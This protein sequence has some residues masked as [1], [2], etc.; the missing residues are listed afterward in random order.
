MAGGRRGGREIAEAQAYLE[1]AGFGR[2]MD[3][4]PG[5]L[6]RSSHGKILTHMPLTP[7]SSYTHVIGALKKAY[8]ISARLEEPDLEFDLEGLT[9]PKWAHHTFRRTA[10]R[11]ARDSMA[12]TGATKGDIDD[13]FG[14][15]Q[16][17]RAKDQQRAYAGIAERSV[18]A[19]CTMM[20]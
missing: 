10:D 3:V 18:R 6:F 15:L 19:R 16:A 9:S 14:W 13:L 12:E 11:M 17:E 20:I 1:A 5:P 4:V 8:T 2:F 7:D